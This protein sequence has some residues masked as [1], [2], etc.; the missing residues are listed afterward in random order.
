MHLWAAGPDA[1]GHDPAARRTRSA[2]SRRRASSGAICRSTIKPAS[3]SNEP[4]G[5]LAA[6]RDPPTAWSASVVVATLPSFIALTSMVM[7][8]SDRERLRSSCADVWRTHRGSSLGGSGTRGPEGRGSSSP[9][10]AEA[11]GHSGPGACACT[12][13]LYSWVVAMSHLMRSHLLRSVILTTIK[14]GHLSIHSEEAADSVRI[15]WLGRAGDA[16]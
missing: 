5:S 10:N 9:P 15:A 2:A 12:R 1:R 14:R 7:S 16:L 8:P 13:D 3:L 6:R 4:W 11:P